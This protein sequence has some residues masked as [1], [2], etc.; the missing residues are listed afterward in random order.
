MSVAK[1]C[2]TQP[3]VLSG[4][5]VTIEAD[6]SRG[7][8]SFLIVGLA[9]KAIDEA[10]DRV[11]SAIKHSGFDSPKSKNHK[12]IISL[13]P[14]DLKKD[15]PLFDLPIAIAYLLAAGDITTDGKERILIGELGLDGTLR[16]VKGI[17][18]CILAAKEAG[19]T[20]VI[21]PFE[22]ATEAALIEDVHIYPATTL[23]AVIDHISDREESPKLISQPPTTI[24]SDWYETTITLEDV[25]GQESA[26]RGLIIAAAGRHNV[27]FVGPPGTGKT[28]LARALR[29]LLPPLSREEAL[30][31]TAIHS[32]V[33][34]E[35]HISTRPPFRSP[36]H[37]AS[38]TALVGGGSNPKP[39]EVTLAHFGLLFMDE[40][41][42][43][44][45]RSLDALRQPLEDR[46]VTISRVQGSAEFPADFILVAALNPYRGT[47]DGTTDLAR[48]MQE[49]YKQKVSGPI[50]DRIDL[51]IEVPHV[52]YETLTTL[53]APT[54]ETA[55]A[56]AQILN[57]RKHMMNRK[58]EQPELP[59][60]NA[61]LSA[62]DIE[63][64]ITLHDDVKDLL[65]LS[66][67]KL[68][69]SP[70]GYHRLI[71]VAR[72]IADLEG[73]ADIQV[74]HVLEALQYRVPL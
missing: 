61:N 45:R 2:T 43:F 1:V 54:G 62:R 58:N 20:E 65:K 70:R 72:T 12:I 29:S 23:R 59:T 5:L 26:K 42:E 55:L 71:K 6:I 33:S 21:V 74:P 3:Q 53:R 49:T 31:V 34:G 22:N 4:T 47:F 8:H 10:K 13:S 39:G 41:P 37:T 35:T 17:L 68:N 18:N 32:L 51:W 69:L 24:S 14:A 16:K 9:G 25:K 56:R 73:S 63:Q 46:V 52:D 19:F 66:S 44:D 36:H 64:S 7:L 67:A 57:A 38:H 15:G 30:A 27:M 28:M 11:S 48:A 40:F 50:L 60:T